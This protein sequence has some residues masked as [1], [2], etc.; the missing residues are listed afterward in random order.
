MM[1]N[2]GTNTG[3]TTGPPVTGRYGDVFDTVNLPRGLPSLRKRRVFRGAVLPM[4]FCCDRSIN[5]RERER[6]RERR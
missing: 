6:E 1:G 4:R 5:K 2:H 3:E